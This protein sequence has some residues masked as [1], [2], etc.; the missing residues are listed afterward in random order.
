MRDMTDEEY[1]A[2]DE[3]LTKTVPKF[4]HTGKGFFTREGFRAIFID[5][6]VY[7][8][9]AAKAI[10]SRQTPDEVITSLIRNLVTVSN[11]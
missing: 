2:L 7:E 1:D 10:A 9:L 8:I 6:D 11:P 5:E 4:G 3:E